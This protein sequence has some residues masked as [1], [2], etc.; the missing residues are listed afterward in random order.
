LT[1]L[2]RRFNEWK[3]QGRGDIRKSIEVLRRTKFLSLDEEQEYYQLYDLLSRFVHTPK[4]FDVYVAHKNGQNRLKRE[5]ICPA[6]TYFDEGHLAE[7]SNAFQSV[8]VVLLKSVATFYPEAFKTDSG[9]LA[10]KIIQG[11]IQ[12]FPEIPTSKR[13]LATLKI[14]K[15]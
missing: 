5:I 9:E 4:E 6:S 15:A 14:A 7:W 11:M 3:K 12:Q 8:F 13:I 10:L 1:R 2:N